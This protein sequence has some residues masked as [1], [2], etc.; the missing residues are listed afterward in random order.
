MKSPA[1]LELQKLA[2]AKAKQDYPGMP[3]SHY[4]GTRVYTDRTANQLTRS[5]IDWLKL[6]GHQAERINCTGRMLDSRTSFIN[7]VGQARTIGNKKWIKT[8]GQRG[9]ADIS[10]TIA[11]KSV[12]IE[13]KIGADRQSPA[14]KAYQTDIERSGGVYLI[15][16]DFQS[17]YNWFSQFT[18]PGFSGKTYKEH[19]KI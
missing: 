17:F 10:A 12:K 6:N 2:I 8:A 5:V 11:G 4:T 1:I 18:N 19:A 13:I 9:T 15:V 16:K 14:Q 7:A 3:E